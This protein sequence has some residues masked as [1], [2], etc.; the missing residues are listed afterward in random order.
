MKMKIALDVYGADHAPE[1]ILKGAFLAA[2]DMPDDELILVGLREEMERICT[3]RGWSAG[4]VTME[5]ATQVITMTD[6]PASS[7]RTKKDSSLVKAAQLVAQGRADA[8]VSA[9][10]TGAVLAAA[11][12]IV[13]RIKGVRRP[14]LAPILP[15]YT[16]QAMLIDCGANVEC[17]PEFLRQFALMGSV[18]MEKVAGIENPRV[19]LANNGAEETK[20][21]DLAV[22]THQILKTQPINFV[23]NAEGRD[24]PMGKCDVVVTDGFTGNLILKTYEGMGK[25]IMLSM[26]DIFY[27]NLRTK[28]GALLLKKEV[29]D[30]RKKMDYTQYGGAPIMGICKPV[31]KSHG[32]SK[33][34]EIRN[35]LLQAKQFSQ[36]GA[37]ESITR[38]MAQ[39]EAAEG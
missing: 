34:G 33:A 39:T 21:T 2:A 31:I 18:Y 35:S 37:I 22:Q 7:V 23:G 36:S 15:T 10:N 9:G 32:S 8:M 24:I 13:K 27:S 14:A 28:L 11:T 6:E 19:A 17:Q 1:E 29:S 26:K 3:Q 16:G 12:L 4:N 30:F 20:G 5:D 38:L 25:F